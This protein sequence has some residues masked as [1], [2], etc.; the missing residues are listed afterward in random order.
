METVEAGR[1]VRAVA[2]LTAPEGWTT[3]K[4]RGLSGRPDDGT[5][6]SEGQ[7]GSKGLRSVPFLFPAVRRGIF[8]LACH[9]VRYV[10]VP[11]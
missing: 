7:A 2:S 6:H 9:R 10:Q 4:P 11:P 8:R 5:A 3:L 1:Q